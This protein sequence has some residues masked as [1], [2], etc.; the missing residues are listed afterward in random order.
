ML[1]LVLRKCCHIYWLQE[2]ENRLSIDTFSP[3]L[4][5][6]QTCSDYPGY[7]WLL[8]RRAHFIF[9]PRSTYRRLLF[10]GDAV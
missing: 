10:Q 9:M 3:E 8:H 4:D 7:M 6:L 2:T 5:A 1:I